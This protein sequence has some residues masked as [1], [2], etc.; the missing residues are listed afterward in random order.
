MLLRIETQDSANLLIIRLK[1]RF[2]GKDA[3]E[4]R[5]LVTRGNDEKGLR[6]PC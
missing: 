6:R 3:E 4:V 1:G 2:T 5:M